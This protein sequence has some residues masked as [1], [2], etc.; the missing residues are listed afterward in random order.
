MTDAAPPADLAAYGWDA[1][2]GEL[3][4]PLLAEGREVGR[5]VRGSRGFDRVRTAAGEVDCPR[6]HTAHRAAELPSPPAVGDWAVVEGAPDDPVIVDLLPRRGTLSRRDPA[7]RD[8]EQIVATNVDAIVL[9][10]GLDRPLRPGRLERS[11]I[12]AHASGAEPVIALTK[13]DLAKHEVEAAAVL[14]ELAADLV[15]LRTS[16]ATGL[17][18]GELATAIA[19]RGTAVILG[20]SGAGKSSL[21]NALVGR[22]A[23]D[24]GEVRAGDRRGRH[25]TTTRELFRLPGGGVVIDTPGV[26]AL[27]LW[28]ELDDELPGVDEAF[29]DIAVLAEGC[30][31]RDCGHRGEPG[32]A[33][34][35]AVDE[36]RLPGSRLERFRAF[37]A[38]IDALERRRRKAAYRA[39]RTPR[40]PR[41]RPS[42]RR[43]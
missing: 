43:R 35:T 38:E 8:L 21:V 12:L 19:E 16:T 15:R 37:N 26:R 20:E 30:R 41:S 6:A 29:P 24:V 36:G 14:D 28:T 7:N 34:A 42:G 22:A 17:G 31:F 33:V 32:C 13:A 10:F 25:T 3:A 27:G 18:L 4:A 39:S 5:V 2:I 9:T 11:L 1:R 23:Q 40:P